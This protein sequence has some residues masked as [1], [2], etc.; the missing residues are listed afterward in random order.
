MN[1]RPI[2][3]GTISRES[4]IWTSTRYRIPNINEIAPVIT[5]V[6]LGRSMELTYDEFEYLNHHF[7]IPQFICAVCLISIILQHWFMKQVESI[8][9]FD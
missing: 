3:A 4:K 5:A 7:T 8:S 6:S 2:G 9:N 1:R